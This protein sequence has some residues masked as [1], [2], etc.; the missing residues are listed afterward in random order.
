M[1]SPYNNIYSLNH[2]ITFLFYLI[3]QEKIPLYDSS[4]SIYLP[5][6]SVQIRWLASI[7]INQGLPHYLVY[8]L[9]LI[10]T[11]LFLLFAYN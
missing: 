11:Q 1:T 6:H 4:N 7:L 3:A 9:R 10:M 2:Q 5:V 8:P